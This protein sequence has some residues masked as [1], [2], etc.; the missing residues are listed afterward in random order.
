MK[1]DYTQ[2]DADILAAIRQTPKEFSAFNTLGSAILNQAEKLA[3]A[4]PP[5][6]WGNEKPGWRVIDQRLQ[7]LRRRGLIKYVKNEGWT[8]Q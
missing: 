7:A 2:I 4:T 8:A 3:K 5:D 6:R 1:A